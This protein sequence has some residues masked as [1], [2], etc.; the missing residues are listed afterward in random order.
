MKEKKIKEG[1]GKEK[2]REEMKER[3][4]ERWMKIKN[5]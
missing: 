2:I 1:K 4:G 5:N 3:K